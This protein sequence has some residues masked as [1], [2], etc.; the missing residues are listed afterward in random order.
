MAQLYHPTLAG[1][2]QAALGVAPWADAQP[3]D[4]AV[5]VVAVAG[6]AAEMTI[7]L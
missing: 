6:P 5:Q 1:A 7:A 4:V 2:L 3:L